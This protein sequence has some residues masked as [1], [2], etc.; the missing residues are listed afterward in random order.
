MH[1][2]ALDGSYVPQRMMGTHQ[3][4]QDFFTDQLAWDC[5]EE[6][7]EV[8]GV[9]MDCWVH[10]WVDCVALVLCDACRAI[11]LP[12]SPA[13]LSQ[14][15]THV[16]LLTFLQHVTP[17]CSHSCS[18]LRCVVY[19]KYAYRTCM[20]TGICMSTRVVRQ[21]ALISLVRR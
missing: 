3:L 18:I 9:M 4:K 12:A 10:F 2:G 7:A 21:R 11:G 20:M 8:A 15:T 6:C 17:A 19:R 5:D 13:V 1:G 16:C 14:H